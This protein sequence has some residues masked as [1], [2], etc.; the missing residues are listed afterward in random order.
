M[1]QLILSTFRQIIDLMKSIVVWH[2]NVFNFTLYDATFSLFAVKTIF[3]LFRFRSGVADDD[4]QEPL[5]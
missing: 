4:E 3:A 2:G 5:C 1:E